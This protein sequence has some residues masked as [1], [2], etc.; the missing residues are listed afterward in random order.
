VS[1]VNGVEN[2]VTLIDRGRST[3]LTFTDCLSFSSFLTRYKM[4]DAIVDR[5]IGFGGGA[6]L[7][8]DCTSFTGDPMLRRLYVFAPPSIIPL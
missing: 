2:L 3:E 6:I 5:P 7:Y 8:E 4:S 1:P